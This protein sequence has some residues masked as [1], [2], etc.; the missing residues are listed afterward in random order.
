MVLRQPRGH[1]RLIR[2][3]YSRGPTHI[4]TIYSSRKWKL[5]FGFPKTR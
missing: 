2:K 1:H 5:V 4:C 3:K